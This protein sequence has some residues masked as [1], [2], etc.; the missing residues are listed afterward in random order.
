MCVI[1][2][3][4][5]GIKIPDDETI[6]ACFFWNDDGAGYAVRFGDNIFISKG[7]MVVDDL[8]KEL[9]DIN[10]QINLTDTDMI[11]H[12]RIATSGGE[13][14]QLTHPFPVTTNIKILSQLTIMTDIA[15]AHNGI[16]SIPH[17]KEESDTV[18]FIKVIAKYKDLIYETDLL[19]AVDSKF[20]I[21]DKNGIKTVG[22][23]TEKDG[24]LFSNMSHEIHE[25]YEG[26]W[27]RGYYNY[28]I[29]DDATLATISDVEC[30]TC[31]TPLI[32]IGTMYYYCSTCT[33]NVK[34]V[35]GEL[36]MVCDCP[37]CHNLLYYELERDVYT[38][39]KCK[40]D[41]ITEYEGKFEL[42]RVNICND[43][44]S[45]LIYDEDWIYICNTCGISIEQADAIVHAYGRKE[46]I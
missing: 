38:C 44:G 22:K 6:K 28:N 2:A 42:L 9:H 23:F 31:T 39:P 45:D 32:A 26:W 1:I 4:K 17:E 33:H 8:L 29:K 27:K 7:F 14:P 25:T 19:E 21:L 18:A 36:V 40:N 37:V 46:K 5:Q 10:N 34:I 24:L 41:Y 3:K 30:P 13:L 16:I 11:F 35:A 15:I 20:A 43:C 12:F